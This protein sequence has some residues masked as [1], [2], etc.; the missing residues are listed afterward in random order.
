[1][2]KAER[3]KLEKS[4]GNFFKEIHKIYTN[5]DFREESSPTY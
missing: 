5:G 1:M 3:G 2:N 4:L